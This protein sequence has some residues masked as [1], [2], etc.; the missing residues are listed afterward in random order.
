MAN[1]SDTPP[2]DDASD[3]TSEAEGGSESDSEASG[4]SSSDE[5]GSEDHAEESGGASSADDADPP[6]ESDEEP[7]TP[8]PAAVRSS[9]PAIDALMALVGDTPAAHVPTPAPPAPPVARPPLPTEPLDVDDPH[10]AGA[11]DDDSPFSSELDIPPPHSV[12]V[13]MPAPEPT[14][15]PQARVDDV[16]PDSGLTLGGTRVTLTGEHLYR[17]SIVRIGGALAQTV[18]AREPHEIRVLAPAAKSVGAVDI[19]VQN[20]SADETLVAQGFTYK[21]LPAPKI[22]SVAP[23]YADAAGGT[24]ISVIGQ[25]FVSDTRVLVGATPVKKIR[26]VDATTLEV[27]LPSGKSGAMMDVIVENPDGKRDVAKRAFKYS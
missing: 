22:A 14:V 5:A 24:E 7:V 16:S 17:V 26:F 3:E 8:P 2:E 18:G 1:E 12:P 21:A 19:T 23:T 10:G 27:V 9:D 11:F 6:D 25:N 15:R 4:A 13:P 20:P